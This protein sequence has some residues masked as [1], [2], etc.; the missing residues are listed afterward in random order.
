[1]CGLTDTQLQQMRDVLAIYDVFILPC[2]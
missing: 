2:I 1:M